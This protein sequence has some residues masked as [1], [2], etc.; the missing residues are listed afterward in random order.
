MVDEKKFVK[1]MCAVKPEN[2]LNKIAIK[3]EFLEYIEFKSEYETKE[4]IVVKEDPTYKSPWTGQETAGRLKFSF[5]GKGKESLLQAAGP[6]IVDCQEELEN[7]D[8]QTAGSPE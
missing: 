1:D 8:S 4:T 6:P 7:F 5:A 2:D 3:T